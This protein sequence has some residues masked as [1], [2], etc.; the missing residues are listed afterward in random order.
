MPGNVTDVDT[1]TDPVQHVLNSEPA[2]EDAWLISIQSLCNRTR[3]L[4]NRLDALPTASAPVNITKSAAVVGVATTLARSDHKHDVATS[5][6]SSIGTANAEGASTNLTRADHVHDHGAQT[7]P[8]HHAAA[9]GS[10]NGFLTSAG[11]TKLAGIAAGAAAV[12]GSAPAD[13]TK[14]AAAVGVGTSAAR[15]DH[16]HDVSTAAAVAI[17]TANAEGAATSLARSDH[18]HALGAAAAKWLTPAV[19]TISFTA[20]LDTVHRVDTSGGAVTATLPTAVGNAGRAIIIKKW[21][22]G[23]VNDITIDGDGSETIDG[24]AN[25]TISAATSATILGSLHLISD[26]ANWAIVARVGS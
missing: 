2:D 16:K 19:N 24:N 17:G 12:T 3:N 15:S 25:A 26:G 14:A 10:N 18:V 5:A 9:D 20:A 1:F 11:F 7:E 8:T 22:T 4:K 6:P 13:V 21:E 23:I